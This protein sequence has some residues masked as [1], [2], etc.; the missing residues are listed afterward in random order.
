MTGRHGPAFSFWLNYVDSR[1]GLWEQAGDAVLAVLPDRLRTAHDL[2]ESALITDDPDVSREDGVLFLGAGH[3]AIDQAA[4]TVIADGDIGTL[5]LEHR[6]RPL[7]TEELLTKIR[8]Q[9]AVDHG[10]IDAAGAPIVSARSLLRLEVL[11]SHTV[12]AEEQFTEV[13]GCL[14]DVPSRVVW[15]EPSADRVRSALTAASVPSVTAP[16]R[17][18]DKNLLL[19][20][21][22]AAH[23]ELDA[24]AAGRGQQLASGADAERV[25]EIAR[26]GDYYTAALASLDKRW[27]DADAQ[28]RELLAA[29]AEATR[30]ER[31]RRLA[32]IDEK[33]QHR[34]ELRPYRLHLVDVP[35]LRL[36]ADVRRG[37]RRWPLV[38]D[39]LP[40][41][42]TVAPTRCPSCDAH[43]P[44]VATK[45]QLGCTTCVP[46][47]VVEPL[48]AP[49]SPKPATAVKPTPKL[50]AATSP[51]PARKP[52]AGNPLVGQSAAQQPPAPKPATR[53][54]A[55]RQAVLSPQ[56]GALAPRPDDRRPFLP[57]KP[58]EKKI[59]D[60]W[61]HV[62]LGERRKLARLIAPESPLAALIRLYGPAGPLHGIGVPAGQLP[63]SFTIGNYDRPV[64]GAR[65]G[66]AGELRTRQGQYEYLLLWSLD[67]LLEEIYPYSAPWHLGRAAS[68]A[69]T[70]TTEAPPPGQVDLDLVATLLSTRTTARHGLAFTARSLAAWWRLPDSKSLIAD[71]GPRVLAATLDRAIRYWSG[72]RD[73]GYREAAEAF[74]A[75]EDLMRKAT[76]LL[77][78]RLQLSATRNW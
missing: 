14:V 51:P 68:F 56:L 33:Y 8:D 10:R 50:S 73:A 64:A 54:S 25:V 37:E 40:L 58:E 35:V 53:K 36:A 38:F 77:Q 7:S 60:F 45:A 55:A 39:Y 49:L 43:A 31:D 57:G 65:G 47:R 4:G 69:R 17:A 18:V 29:R 41:L 32:E 20:A 52:L 72:A 9:V 76:P 22:I 59:A 67:R 2:P 5:T 46:V 44:L 75:D 15:P 34:H 19:R 1:G 27:V 16:R 28:R 71:F 30:A 61:D 13:A 62:A 24:A 26:A 12:S 74:R 11:V 66:T 6:S 70:R 78:K 3:P 23:E 63:V 21:L 42:G 48:V